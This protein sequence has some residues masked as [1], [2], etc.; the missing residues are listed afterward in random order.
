M[1][2]EMLSLGT[3]IPNNY[4]AAT[5]FATTGPF[6]GS[7]AFQVPKKGE[8]LLNI[9]S[10]VLPSG[11]GTWNAEVSRLN[12]EKPLIVPVNLSGAGTAVTSV[13]Y[14]EKGQYIFDRNKTKI[15]SPWFYL[16]YANGSPLMD[17]NNTYVQPGFGVDSPETFRF[18][19]IPESGTYFV[20]VLAEKSPNDWSASIIS[21]PIIPLPLGPAR[22]IPQP[23]GNGTP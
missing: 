6:N 21:V 20:T 12:V 22:F 19:L 16:Q 23:S 10:W 9:T 7:V 1:R 15:D 17:P 13:F 4:A 2:V 14:L 8:Y 5:N 18:V 3:V 11:G